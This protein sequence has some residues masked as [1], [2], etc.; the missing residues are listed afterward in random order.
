[1]G[2]QI[3]L[4]LIAGIDSLEGKLGSGSGSLLSESLVK[5]RESFPLSN[6]DGARFGHIAKS[7]IK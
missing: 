5:R 1:M 3:A 4:S 7:S 6:P 2:H